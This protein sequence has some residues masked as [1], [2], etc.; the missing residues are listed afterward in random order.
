MT[1]HKKVP[2]FQLLIEKV[3]WETWQTMKRSERSDL[4]T[5]LMGPK[6]SRHSGD[7][8]QTCLQRLQRSP[9]LQCGIYLLEHMIIEV[10]I[11]I[12]PLFGNS[13]FSTMPITIL[14]YNYI[15]EIITNP[16]LHRKFIPFCVFAVQFSANLTASGGFASDSASNT[17]RTWFHNHDATKAFFV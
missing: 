15:I 17:L 6:S 16:S 13:R 7:L 5:R 10:S 11:D 8:I 9:S 2:V 4:G 12:F 1:T 14:N 3:G